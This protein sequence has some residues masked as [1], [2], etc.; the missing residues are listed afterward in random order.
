METDKSEQTSKI[1]YPVRAT[2]AANPITG[3]SNSSGSS[4]RGNTECIVPGFD[5]AEGTEG[6]DMGLGDPSSGDCG[7]RKDKEVVG[8]SP[9]M[10]R[11]NSCLGTTG[12]DRAGR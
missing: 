3:V 8:I 9:A 4:P 12:L 1:E 6:R 2:L 7:Y 10:V 11:V 5:T